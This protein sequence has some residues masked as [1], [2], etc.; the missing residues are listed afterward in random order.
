[1]LLRVSTDHLE[2]IPAAVNDSGEIEVIWSN[3]LFVTSVLYEEQ[4]ISVTDS[5]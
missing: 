4:G 3:K 5:M 1:M 2:L